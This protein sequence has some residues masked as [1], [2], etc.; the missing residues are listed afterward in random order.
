MEMSHVVRAVIAL[1]VL[2]I[3]GSAAAQNNPQIALSLPA[4]T[5]IQSA[6]AEQLGTAVSKAIRA[7]PP[8][9]AAA[10]TAQA[11]R[12]LKNDDKVKAAAVITA[13]LKAGRGVDI[14]A[15]VQACCAAKP[16]LAPTVAA[17]AAALFPRLAMAISYV[18][19][20]AAPSEARAIA[21][22][23]AAA[24]PD[25]RDLIFASIRSVWRD[26]LDLGALGFAMGQGINPANF[27]AEGGTPPTTS[28]PA[29]LSAP[30]PAP[31]PAPTPAPNPSPVISPEL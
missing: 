10:I 21:L 28:G 8:S 24:V 7:N 17:T 12:G 13:A 9:E 27:V 15:I 22:A 31:N 11:I 1:A 14:L 16:S 30:T 3:F 4:G 5:T 29:A 26:G 18:A 20:Q 25:Q 19:A 23:V 6:T 2:G